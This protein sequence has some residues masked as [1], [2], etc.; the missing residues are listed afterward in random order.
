M[1]D[2]KSET[3]SWEAP[4]DFTEFLGERLNLERDE[5]V[6]LLG[7]CLIE[8]EPDRPYDIIVG[9]ARAAA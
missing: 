5:A 2:K 1:N 8:Y 7:R 9:P 6:A 4:P 3:K